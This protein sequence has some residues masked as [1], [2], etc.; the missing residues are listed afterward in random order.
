MTKESH[1]KI[2][3]KSILPTLIIAIGMLGFAIYT[4]N[5]L[6][7]QSYNSVNSKN[8]TANCDISGYVLA[9]DVN[10]TPYGIPDDLKINANQAWSKYNCQGVLLGDTFGNNCYGSIGFTYYGLRQDGVGLFYCS[11]IEKSIIDQKVQAEK[12]K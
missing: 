4:L 6:H 3:W 7:N 5:D 10:K 8:V 11:N 2:P 12:I 1:G 9:K